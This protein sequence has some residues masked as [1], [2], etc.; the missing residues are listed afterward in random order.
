MS[1]STGTYYFPIYNGIKKMPFRV[2]ARRQ[3]L[4][5][6][7]RQKPRQIPQ[8]I[9][10]PIPQQVIEQIQVSNVEYYQI[11]PSRRLLRD[12]PRHRQ[13]GYVEEEYPKQTVCNMS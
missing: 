9:P 5:P 6:T 12:S 3:I 4:H 10:Q 2:K 1:N 13:A 7:P 8:P 11:Q